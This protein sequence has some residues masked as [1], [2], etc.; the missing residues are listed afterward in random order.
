[1]HYA[2]NEKPP[3]SGTLS[4]GGIE[5]LETVKYEVCVDGEKQFFGLAAP[6]KKYS[7]GPEEQP[8]GIWIYTDGTC[9]CVAS[10]TIHIRVWSSSSTSFHTLTALEFR[11]IPANRLLS[12]PLVCR[13]EEWAGGYDGF[14]DVRADSGHEPGISE[15]LR[16]MFKSGNDSTYLP[17]PRPFLQ[18]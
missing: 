1:M 13:L 11:T 12:I 14:W 8:D 17:P 4:I 6:V 18:T 3:V 7:Q 5:L 10:P 15:A 9:E 2:G 16:Q